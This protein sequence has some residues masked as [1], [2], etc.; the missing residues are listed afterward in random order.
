MVRSRK[1]TDLEAVKTVADSVQRWANYQ[2]LSGEF[3]SV[4]TSPIVGTYDWKAYLHEEAKLAQKREG[5]R[6]PRKAAEA[7][8]PAPA[9]SA[10]YG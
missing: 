8:A 6:K 10:L 4:E 7:P 2:S 9:P 1:A 3:D 5:E